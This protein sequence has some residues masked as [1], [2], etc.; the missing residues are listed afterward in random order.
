VVTRTVTG[1]G[2]T[3][4]YQ[5]TAAGAELQAL[6]DTLGEWGARWAFGDPRRDE[7]D[8]VLLQWFMRRRIDLD[9]LPKPRTVIEFR[10]DRTRPSRLWL[11][12]DR[13]DV[14]VCLK[15]PGFDPDVVVSGS[16]AAFYEAWLGRVPL[17][18]AMDDGLVTIA[19]PP[20][21][22]RGFVRSLQLSPM[23]Q[24]VSATARR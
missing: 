22:T 19:G 3:S 24:A 9:K 20:A 5:L 16:L 23:A 17:S 18:R 6:I 11:V 21:M 10:F 7:L 15:D 8:P 13:D 14:S 12:I 4:A 2:R 1:G